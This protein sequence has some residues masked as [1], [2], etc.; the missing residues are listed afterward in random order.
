MSLRLQVNLLFALLV[1]STFA[2]M[3]WFD[4]INARRAV[5]Q[6]ITA[7]NRIATQLLQS[8]IVGN[9]IGGDSARLVVFLRTLGRVRSTDIVLTAS[10]GRVLYTA[11][12]SPYKPG[13]NAPA[14]YADLISPAAMRTQLRLSDSVLDISADASRAVLDG[15]D[16]AVKL[17]LFGS[18]VLVLGCALMFWL[19]GRMTAP[20]RDIVRGLERFERGHYGARLPAFANA[21]AN[22]IAR[23]FNRMGRAVQDHLDARAEA[24]EAIARLRQS[25]EL[26]DIVQCRI[27]DERRQIARELHDETSQTLTAIRSMSLALAQRLGEGTAAHSARLINDSATHLHAAIHAMIPRLQAPDIE[28]LGLADALE[29]QVAR[30]RQQYPHIAFAL[31]CDALHETPGDRTRLGES[32]GLTAYRVVQEA[33]TNALRHA[34]P[35]IIRIAL[36]YALDTLEITVQD[37]GCGLSSDWRRPGHYGIRGMQE[38]V[39]ALDGTFAIA[40]QES[41][42][43][44]VHARLPMASPI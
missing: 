7:S 14:W 43:V 38:R 35:R 25:R 24:A 29:E 41:G 4:L 10:G 31:Q 23:A 20:L 13:R 28:G 9:R 39:R 32:Y 15:W 16:D 5:E 27:E 6:E 2:G 37:D 12:K 30:W 1:A 21:E 44:R 26:A 11:P 33:T 19:L 34:H 17:V 18:A 22:V 36:R 8:A 3:L 42:G 40:T